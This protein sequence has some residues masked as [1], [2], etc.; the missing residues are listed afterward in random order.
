MK[1]NIMAG[2]APW[3]FSSILDSISD[4]IF[5][6]DSNGITV[7]CNQAC[8]DMYKINQEDVLGVH[9]KDLEQQ[10]IFSPSVAGLVLDQKREVTIIHENREGRK[11]LSTGTPILNYNGQI[12]KIITTSRDITELS[13]LQ[14]KLEGMDQTFS[15]S[16]PKT[17]NKGELVAV[18]HA[19]FKVL[20]LA[21]RLSTVDSTVLITGD[22][23]VGKGVIARYLHEHGNRAHSPFITVNC[24]AIP[25]NL[26]ESE[27][28]GY[29]KGAFTGARA[30]GKKGIFEAAQ[31]GTVFLDEI[32]ELPLNLQVKLLQVIQERYITKVGS[33]KKK[34]VDVRII[35]ATNKDL[36]QLVS[37]NK[38]RKDLY[39]RLNV[40][41]IYVPPLC[42]RR[43]DILP[44][45]N[46]FLTKYNNRYSQ[47]KKIS[48][49]ALDILV[50]FDWPGNIRE[51]Q[52]IVERLVL[53]A[54]EEVITAQHLP[55]FLFKTLDTSLVSPLIR[56][57][58]KESLDAA[59]KAILSKALDT[60]SSTR[61]MAKA[62]GV[63]QPTVV[64]KLQK[65]GLVRL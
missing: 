25:E 31:N 39:Y 54:N 49:D 59:E 52:N 6:D 5:I 19:M 10:G 23:G 7:W 11:L 9:V 3:E 8:M 42:Q 37:E 48:K 15:E 30:D 62:L 46:R 64:R 34:P 35:S 29:D 55:E 43:E 41:P 18:S 50:R 12:S 53:T 17:A 33:T 32:S 44:L 4:A 58:L 26:I 63:S 22:S 36:H 56:R 28:F 24:G 38:F 57:S 51:L 60:Y 61:A 65:H 45:I 2:L 20:Q 40:V 1:N 47:N 21:V 27:L 13:T 16:S 14:T